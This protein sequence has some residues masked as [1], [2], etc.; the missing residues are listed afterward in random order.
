MAIRQ[1]LPFFIQRFDNMYILREI[2]EI[3][4]AEMRQKQNYIKKIEL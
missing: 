2:K 4:R 1:E 3:L